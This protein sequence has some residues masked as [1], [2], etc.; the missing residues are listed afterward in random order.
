M[1]Q[2]AQKHRKNNKECIMLPY[3]KRASKKERLLH[4]PSWQP[5]W[6]KW[7]QVL[8]I[9]QANKNPQ[10]ENQHQ[11]RFNTNMKSKSITWSH[12]RTA[13]SRPSA[14]RPAFWHS[15]SLCV[16]DHRIGWSESRSFFRC[17]FSRMLYDD[18]FLTFSRCFWAFLRHPD[19]FWKRTSIKRT[20]FGPSYR[21]LMPRRGVDF[22][23]YNC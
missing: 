1:H 16:N 17:S 15:Q 2:N 4:D 6:A 3:F 9:S 11:T 21:S 8:V 5:K 18:V 12:K 19:S 13:G 22:H 23:I 14:W 10:G 7:Q 20:T